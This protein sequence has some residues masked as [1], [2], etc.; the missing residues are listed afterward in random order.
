[1]QY[2]CIL[3]VSFLHHLGVTNAAKALSIKKWVDDVMFVK[4]GITA[5]SLVYNINGERVYG[6][7]RGLQGWNV[8]NFESYVSQYARRHSFELEQ[9]HLSWGLYTKAVMGGKG[10]VSTKE[11]FL[12]QFLG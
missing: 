8:N 6:A 5:S 10:G 3:F 9:Q 7:F 1:M 12:G 11:I 4:A 2:C